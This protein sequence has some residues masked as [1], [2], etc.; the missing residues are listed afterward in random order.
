MLAGVGSLEARAT[1]YHVVVN[2][3]QS[4]MGESS[5]EDADIAS[6]QDVSARLA[7]PAAL[8]MFGLRET[9]RVHGST[10]PQ[11][12]YTLTR[13][14]LQILE[15]STNAA[16]TIN[17]WRSRWATWVAGACFTCVA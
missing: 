7:E 16:D 1:V 15:A 5:A 17:Y 14:L 11:A 3:V 2:L 10:D 8:E 9:E 12:I 6:L 4:L 13:E